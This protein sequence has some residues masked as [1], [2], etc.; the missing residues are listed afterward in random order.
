VR[1][2]VRKADQEDQ[3]AI[4]ALV[5]QARLNPRNLSWARF[6][7]AETDQGIVGAAQVRL[8]STDAENWPF[9]GR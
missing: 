9:P 6:V 3:A 4:T 7:V 1:V 5:R 8:L 2:T